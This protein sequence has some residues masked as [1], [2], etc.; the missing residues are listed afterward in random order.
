MSTSNSRSKTP[1]TKKSYDLH[2]MYKDVKKCEGQHNPAYLTIAAMLAR[3][4]VSF[5]LCGV[6]AI[7]GTKM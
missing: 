7:H 6:P 3:S 5:Y 2:V 1:F 4:M